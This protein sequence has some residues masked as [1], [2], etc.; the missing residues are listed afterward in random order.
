VIAEQI[1][2]LCEGKPELDGKGILAELKAAS[3]DAPGAVP[4]LSTLYRFLRAKGLDQRQKMPHKDHRA[5]AFDL[6]GDC[7]QGDVM[8]GPSLP[9][10]DGRRSK[11]FLLAILD[12]ATRL[13]C[14]AQF[15]FEQHLSSLKD[16][17]KQAF[18]KRGIPRRLYFDNGKIFRS[19]M[20]LQLCARLGIHLIHTRPYR[21]QGRAKLERWF[22]T[23]RRGFLAR[24]DLDKVES[25]DALNRL[26]HAW[27]EGEYHVTAHS[28]L[29]GQ[30][31][32]D[33]WLALSEGIRPVPR[34]IDLDRLFLEEVRRRVKK[35]GTFSLLGK[36]FEAGP[37]VIGVRILIRYTPFDLRRVL[38]VDQQGVE[39][40]AFPVD[41]RGNRF[42]KRRSESDSGTAPKKAAPE[43]RAVEDLA[44]KIEEERKNHEQQ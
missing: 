1:T 18:L 29:E 42:V 23:V 32:L 35:D 24:I 3:K 12:D 25:L 10:K 30:T 28:S 8:F 6:A 21:P 9:E 34:D 41:L 26:F 37:A 17:L 4:S 38:F 40:A 19:R 22:G 13:V 16:C 11:T 43:L 5:Y 20:L 15:Y 31:P 44:R 27:I 39:K 33:R 36:V 7:W 2:K 14:H